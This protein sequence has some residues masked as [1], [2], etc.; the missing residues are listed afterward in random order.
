MTVSD[1]TLGMQA[2]QAEAAILKEYAGLSEDEMHAELDSVEKQMRDA[3]KNAQGLD[4][5]EKALLG[6]LESTIW[7]GYLG[8]DKAELVDELTDLQ[9]AVERAL[10]RGA[11][12]E[13][14]LRK[15]GRVEKV[16][17]EMIQDWA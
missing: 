3:P 1:E 7:R 17:M 14:D 12:G 15:F 9:E 4:A 8:M 13:A 2:A 16:L 10:A 6:A 11:E 5:R